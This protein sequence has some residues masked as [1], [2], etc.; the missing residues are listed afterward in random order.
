MSLNDPWIKTPVRE[1]P[2]DTDTG[3]DT[4]SLRLGP[5]QSWVDRV[6]AARAFLAEAGPDLVSLEQLLHS[7]HPAGLSFVL[8]QLLRAI[9]VQIPVQVMFHEL[10]LGEQTGAR[11]KTRVFVLIPFDKNFLVRVR[12][13][14]LGINHGLLGRW[15][16]AARRHPIDSCSIR[17]RIRQKYPN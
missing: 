2:P 14:R 8:P 4:S 5:H 11:L 13:A 12:S 3:T 1:I 16:P 6:T 10:W 9:I 15:E 7:F 17:R